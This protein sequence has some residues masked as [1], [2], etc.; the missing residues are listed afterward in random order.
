MQLEASGERERLKTVLRDRLV[1]CGWKQDITRHARGEPSFCGDVL[2]RWSN[3]V[4]PSQPRPGLR[5]LA[6]QAVD[7]RYECCM[8][9]EGFMAL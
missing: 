6:V 3:C 5:R 2:R 9:V 8:H 1:E 7:Y 4:G